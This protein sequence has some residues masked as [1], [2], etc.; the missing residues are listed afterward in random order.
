MTTKQLNH[1]RAKRGDSME[2]GLLK[3]DELPEDG[4]EN[5]RQDNLTEAEK[6]EERR[7]ALYSSDLFE[8]D[9]ANP[10][11]SKEFLEDLIK[12]KQDEQALNDTR[13][14]NSA[15]RDPY[16]R[17]PKVGDLVEIPFVLGNTYSY[18]QRVIMHKAMAHIR[19]KTCIRFVPKRSNHK[20]YIVIR[21]TK[22]SCSS[23]VGRIGN[24]KY[25]DV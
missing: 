22:N 19:Q 9:I 24:E 15:I 5:A 12:T 7:N 17:W 4:L 20:D 3:E 6:E 8:G 16:F 21:N 23:S 2:D 1:L 11:F 13:V 25:D 10:G 18:E 14:Q